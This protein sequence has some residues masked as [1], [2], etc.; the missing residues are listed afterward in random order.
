MI[1]APKEAVERALKIATRIVTQDKNRDC[2]VSKIGLRSRYLAF[3]A[4][5]RVFPRA[6]KSSVARAAGFA[7]AEISVAQRRLNSIR[8]SARDVASGKTTHGA[9]WWSQAR[10][11][12]IVASI[13]DF[14]PAPSPGTPEGHEKPLPPKIE[15]HF[16]EA[17]AKPPYE[18]TTR[19]FFIGAGRAMR[20]V[21]DMGDM[22]PRGRS[23]LDH[24]RARK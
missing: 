22:P 17:N 1:Y 2:D 14:K 15:I 9:R 24:L 11:D 12:E 7:D 4:L 23:A 16:V 3:G 13:V 5:G 6:P 18:L 8:W 19:R 20:H 10:E 21:V